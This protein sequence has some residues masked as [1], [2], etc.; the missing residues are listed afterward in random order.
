M[1][2]LM[3][4]R[5]GKI[6]IRIAKASQRPVMGCAKKGFW[7]LFSFFSSSKRLGSR[8]L[9]ATP[10]LPFLCAVWNAGWSRTPQ[11]AEA[12]DAAYG[13]QMSARKVDCQLYNRPAWLRAGYTIVSMIKLRSA[14][15]ICW[16]IYYY[17]WTL[18][19]SYWKQLNSLRTSVFIQIYDWCLLWWVNWSHD[20]PRLQQECVLLLALGFIPNNVEFLTSISFLDNF[21][22]SMAVL[23]TFH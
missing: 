18:F 2:F 16:N 17:G 20:L 6:R 12:S 5:G 8:N 15:M 1:K 21:F 19:K 11:D 22:F 23:R 7:G 4:S 14:D 9:H 13:C 3:P 10:V